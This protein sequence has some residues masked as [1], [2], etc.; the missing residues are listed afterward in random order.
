[1]RYF[2]QAEEMVK[3]FEK[4][5]KDVI[6]IH[7]YHDSL[8]KRLINKRYYRKKFTLPNGRKSYFFFKN[9]EDKQ[10]FLEKYM[11]IITEGR[12]QEIHEEVGIF[13]GFPPKASRYFPIKK[14]ENESHINIPINYGG[15]FFASYKE[16]IQDDVNWLLKNKPL[17]NGDFILFDKDFSIAVGKKNWEKDIW[18]TVRFC[19][20]SLLHTDNVA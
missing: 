20:A 14:K 2:N 6:W 19:E 16:T 5:V 8:V 3:A 17:K 12:I 4:G 10:T 11:N 9:K 18:D 1:M 15:M 13:L 7:P